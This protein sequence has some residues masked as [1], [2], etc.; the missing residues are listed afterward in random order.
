MQERLSSNKAWDLNHSQT[1]NLQNST[2]GEDSCIQILGS[3][4][5]LLAEIAI[6]K[7]SINRLPSYLSTKSPIYNSHEYQEISILMIKLSRNR[8]NIPG[9]QN[10]PKMYSDPRGSAAKKNCPQGLYHQD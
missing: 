2:G 8:K 9:V 1:E 6:N 10:L 4:L 5:G 7:L 3:V